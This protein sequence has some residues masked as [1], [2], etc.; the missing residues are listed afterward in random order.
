LPQAFC[1]K[2]ACTLDVPMLGAE[3]SI[4]GTNLEAVRVLELNRFHI[5]GDSARSEMPGGSTW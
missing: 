2:F 1:L 5:S 3:I 4:F